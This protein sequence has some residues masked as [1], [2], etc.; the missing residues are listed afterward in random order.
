M[1]FVSQLLR[2]CADTA[3]WALDALIIEPLQGL[4]AML[5]GVAQAGPEL[6]Q[7]AASATVDAIERH[8]GP[9]GQVRVQ[10]GSELILAGAKRMVPPAVVAAGFWIWWNPGILYLAS[11][12]WV[13]V[14]ATCLV[15]D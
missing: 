7:A 13:L 5:A 3:R 2:C 11:A 14:L 10:Q 6:A 9:D 12:A 15:A 1:S 4:R 8:L